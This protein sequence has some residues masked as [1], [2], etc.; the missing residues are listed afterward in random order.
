MP[1]RR[2]G[3]ALGIPPHPIGGGRPSFIVEWAVSTK[4]NTPIIESFHVLVQ[5]QLAG[6]SLHGLAMTPGQEIR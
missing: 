4:V 6:A 2:V 5:P 1:L 3:A